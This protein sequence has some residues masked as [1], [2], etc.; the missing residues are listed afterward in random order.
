MADSTLLESR[1][2]TNKGDIVLD[3]FCGSG[4]TCV[5]AKMPS[6]KYIGI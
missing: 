4:T 6:R 1:F 3:L 5:A 2:V